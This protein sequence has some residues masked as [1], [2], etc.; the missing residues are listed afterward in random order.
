[1]FAISQTLG[2]PT[3][4]SNLDSDWLLRCTSLG[5]HRYHNMKSFLF[6]LWFQVSLS[7]L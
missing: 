3:R 5:Y 6:V 1:M 4:V 7:Q 2:M